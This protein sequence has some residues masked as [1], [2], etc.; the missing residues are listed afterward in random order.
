M[1]KKKLNII[2]RMDEEGNITPFIQTTALEQQQ[3]NEQKKTK[4]EKITSAFDDGYQFGDLTR[5]AGKGVKAIG[6]S[7]ASNF[8]AGAFDDGY[9]IGDIGKTLAGTTWNLGKAGAKGFMR[10]NEQMSDWGYNRLADV[11][12]FVGFDKQANEWR[13]LSEEDTT[14]SM[15]QDLNHIIA[16]DYSGSKSDLDVNDYAKGMFQDFDE[17]SILS[18][19]GN[20]TAEEIARIMTTAGY[21]GMLSSGAG[22]LTSM[23]PLYMSS[24]SQGENEARMAGADPATAHKFGILSGLIEIGTESMWGGLGA[25]VKALGF[26]EGW[27]D[28]FAS[29]FTNKIKSRL[30]RNVLEYGIDSTGEGFEELASGWLGAYAKKLTYMKDADIKQLMEDENLQD[31]FIEGMTTSLF[32][33]SPSF[34]QRTVQGRDLKTGFNTTQENLEK[35]LINEKVA[36]EGGTNKVSKKRYSEI[37]KE[38]HKNIENGNVIGVE[39]LETAIK[40]GVVSQQEVVDSYTNKDVRNEIKSKVIGNNF[41]NNAIENGNYDQILNGISQDLS[42]T[43]TIN[44]YQT[45]VAQELSNN[46]EYQE[47]FRQNPQ[48][49]NDIVTQNAVKLYVA[50]EINAKTNEIDTEF[51]RYDASDKDVQAMKNYFKDIVAKKNIRFVFEDNLTNEK[52]QNA[53]GYITTASDGSTEIHLNR[54]SDRNMVYTTIH[55]LYHLIK[56]TELEKTLVQYAVNNTGSEKFEEAK[57]ALLE[58]YNKN[59]INEEAAADMAATLLEDSNFINYLYSDNSANSKSFIKTVGDYVIKLLKNFTEKGR[60]ENAQIKALENFK[61][62]WVKNYNTQLNNLGKDTKYEVSAIGKN[63]L[64]ERLSL[65]KK[66]DWTYNNIVI[67]NLLPKVLQKFDTENSPAVIEMHALNNILSREQYNSMAPDKGWLPVK[68][69]NGKNFHAVGMLDYILAIHGMDDPLAVY[70]Y[71]SSDK[72]HNTN[73]FVIVTKHPALVKNSKDGS[74]KKGKNGEEIWGNMVVAYQI[75]DKSDIDGLPKVKGKP[76]KANIIKTVFSNENALTQ[77]EEKVAKGEMVRVFKGEGKEI[78]YN[79]S[80]EDM[81][82]NLKVFEIK[83]GPLSNVKKDSEGNTLSPAIRRILGSGR[84]SPAMFNDKGE[85]QKWWHTASGLNEIYESL[86]PVLSETK[87]ILA[88]GHTYLFLTDSRLMSEGY[89]DSPD[90]LGEVY[91]KINNMKQLE[92]VVNQINIREIGEKAFSVEKNGKKYQL[93]RKPTLDEDFVLGLTE[94]E[95]AKL[96]NVWGPYTSIDAALYHLLENP[97]NMGLINKIKSSLATL[98]NADPGNYENNLEAA[99][100]LVAKAADGEFDIKT[101]VLKE[102]DNQSDLFRHF[103]RDITSFDSLLKK[104][105]LYG[106]YAYPEQVF[107][108]DVNDVPMKGHS[109]EYVYKVDDSVKKTPWWKNTLQKYRKAVEAKTGVPVK[110]NDLENFLSTDELASYVLLVENPERIKNGLPPYQAIRIKNVNDSAAIKNIDVAD[111]LIVFDDPRLMKSAD[112]KTPTNDK[113]MNYSMSNKG[114]M[115]EQYLKTLKDTIPSRAKGKG[116]NFVAKEHLKNKPAPVINKKSTTSDIQ[117]N[118][119]NMTEAIKNSN[120]LAIPTSKVLSPGEIANLTPESAKSTPN[121]PNYKVQTGEGESKIT[122]SIKNSNFLSQETKDRLVEDAQINS[123]QTTT[124]KAEIEEA[125]RRIDSGGAKETLN[126]FNKETKFDG[127]D[128]AQGLM[129]LKLYEEAGDFENATK[130]TRKLHDITRQYGQAIQAMSMLSRMTPEGMAY[131]AQTELDEMFNKMI[132]GKSKEWIQANRDKFNL[133]PQEIQAIMDLTKQAAN[134]TDDYQKRVDIAK[135]QK[136]VSDKLPSSLSNKAKSYFRISMLF[137]PK[138]QVRNIVGNAMIAPVNWTSDI[139]AT[140]I[141]KKLAQKS[142]YRTVANFN[143]KDYIKGFKKGAY[144][145][146][147]DFKQ[148]INTRNTELNRYEQLQ[149]KSF[150][151]KNLIGKSLNGVE[152]V[153]NFAMDG[154]DRIFY[155]GEFTNALNNIMATNGVDTPTQEMIE[156]AQNVALQRTWNDSNAYTKFV[157]NFRSNV[158]KFG[159]YIHLG[160]EQ[161]GLGDILLPFAKTPANLTKAIVDYSPLSFLQALGKRK[162]LLNNIENG[163][164]T[165]QQQRAYVDTMGKAFAG[166]LLYIA[167]GGLAAAGVATGESDEDKDVRDF[168]KNTLGISSYSIK[169]PWGSFTY[170][171]AQPIAAPLAIMT[172]AVSAVK[173]GDEKGGLKIL[174]AMLGSLNSGSSVLMDQSFLQSF[175]DVMTNNEGLVTGML[176]EMSELPARGIPTLVSQINDMIDGTKRE[177]YY[178]GHII[179]SGLNYAKSKIPGL[180]QTLAPKRNTLGQEIKKYGGNNNVFNVFF[181]PANV[182]SQNMGENAKEIYRIYEATGDKNVMPSVAPYSDTTTGHIYTP[183]ERSE[184][185]KISGDIVNDTIDYLLNYH[186]DNTGY[187]YE[188]LSDSEKAEL[189]AKINSFARQK[190]R[191]EILGVEMSDSYKNANKYYEQGDLGAYYLDTEG[192]NYALNYPE[193]YTVVTSTMTWK[194]YQKHSKAISN[195]RANTSNDKEETIKYI[196]NIPASDFE[197]GYDDIPVKVKRAMLTK[198]YYPSYHD[199][200]TEIVNAVLSHCNM[201]TKKGRELAAGELK[202]LGF[203]NV[204][205]EGGNVYYD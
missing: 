113:N 4:Q 134:E 80:A 195:L 205:I 119:A 181:N 137:N 18:E 17:N 87:K 125:I 109:W 68:D 81:E 120:D 187:D 116:I 118:I 28:K 151:D 1:A 153:L 95:R 38:I 147:N 7:V 66:V 108:T 154:G 176:Q 55:E 204:K 141:D 103:A 64:T 171:W 117:N 52:G 169:T 77:Y 35:E 88:D 22:G 44:L 203:K 144:E 6:K 150:S 45:Q 21:G 132:D 131:H 33:G 111:D 190:A 27:A 114:T 101:G 156:T 186:D 20:Q 83:N 30:L 23:L 140:A 124:N 112:N 92:E 123:Y 145:S 142:G 51:E 16:K 160:N 76:V 177:T 162:A 115:W 29:K 110:P 106:V 26:N 161:F 91:P 198:T 100:F 10:A 175:N 75:T 9:Q 165:M 49:Y 164:A 25:G 188:S 148:D 199:Y 24:A 94:S 48:A 63:E 82:G 72:R 15:G 12:D 104:S 184:Y 34:F 47:L 163:T 191:Q 37:K 43:N 53:D 97:L 129:Y 157:L 41:V 39:G 170:D 128:V 31:Q 155:E 182:N 54:N 158:N 36:E 178:K 149:G 61:N 197:G 78:P 180:S 185:Q 121:L 93:I 74:L 89:A 19:K 57:K 130:V 62:L 40:D 135:I 167:A 133:T 13:K 86:D 194:N 46:P 127:T 189:L 105:Y 99:K 179:Q 32:M 60:A 58:S 90:D 3:L 69:D 126:W 146:Y 200:D 138:T 56:G 122:K 42:A 50:D 139:F 159:G 136:I 71:T 168:L 8:Q 70:Q 202:K 79:L 84:V 85:L 107:V 98:K 2:G 96:K 166:T 193:K 201:N 11:A 152:R 65:G 5:T 14:S 59:E 196:N 174:E 172:N 143:A 73:D 183:E 173:N 102:Y 192:A 67:K